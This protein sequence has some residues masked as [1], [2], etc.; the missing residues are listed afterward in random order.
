MIYSHCA[1][2]WQEVLRA[3]LKAKK[4][5]LERHL[6]QLN[7]QSKLI[8][9]VKSGLPGVLMTFGHCGLAWTLLPRGPSHPQGM[10]NPPTKTA[11]FEPQV[12]PSKSI[13]RQGYTGGGICLSG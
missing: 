4:V 11:N 9:T 2:R 5:D 3:K 12:R 7:Q 6:Q 13:S 1:N 8:E 10:Q